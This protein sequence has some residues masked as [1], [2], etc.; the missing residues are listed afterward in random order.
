[1]SVQYHRAM[2]SGHEMSKVHLHMDKAGQKWRDKTEDNDLTIPWRFPCGD[3]NGLEVVVLHEAQ[4]VNFQPYQ[5][6]SHSLL[7]LPRFFNHIARI[8]GVWTQTETNNQRQTPA[9]SSG[10]ASRRISVNQLKWDVILCGC[11]TH[12]MLTLT[13]TWSLKIIYCYPEFL[14]A[15]ASQRFKSVFR[16]ACAWCNAQ[17]KSRYQ[18]LKLLAR[19]LCTLLTRGRTML[20]FAASKFKLGMTCA[21][22][23]P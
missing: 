8:V 4:C 13:R 23:K 7:I 2:K 1:M 3:D 16:C 5:I 15:S 9:C 18:N 14:N 20:N 12:F 11:A 10:C 21:K 22:V 17:W 6:C 19:N